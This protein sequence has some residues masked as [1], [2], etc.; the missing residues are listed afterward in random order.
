MHNYLGYL[1]NQSW[2]YGVAIFVSFF[3]SFINYYFASIDP[4][5]LLE[6]FGP[7]SYLIVGLGLV[8]VIL[9]QILRT[10]AEMTAA[11][12]FHHQVR[13]RRDPKHELVTKGV[14]QISR[15]PSYLGWYIWAVGTQ[16]MMMNIVSTIFF[17][18][19]S[20]FFFSDRIP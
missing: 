3:E 8:M 20:W 11:S 12:N 7:T 4:F 5:N 9:G 14:Y 15:H 17:I 1:I 13:Y 2:A 19:T 18:I 6:D 10:S 16:V